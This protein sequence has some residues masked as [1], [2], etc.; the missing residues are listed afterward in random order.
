MHALPLTWIEISKS[1]LENNL[2]MFKSLAHN[3]LI[4]PVV[5][6]NAYGHGLLEIARLCQESSSADWLCTASLSDA[7]FLRT[8]GIIKPILVLSYLDE[9]PALAVHYGIDV[10]VYDE[11]TIKELSAIGKAI[12]KPV[13]IHIKVDTGMSRLGFF[14][15]EIPALIAKIQQL[16]GLVISGIATHFSEVAQENQQYT[17]QQAQAFNDLLLFLKKNDF[18]IPIRHAA[19]SAGAINITGPLWNFTRL[20]AGLYGLWPSAFTQQRAQHNH[21]GFTLQPIMTWKTRIITMRRLPAHSFVGYDRTYTTTRDTTMAILPMGYFD[22]YNRRLTNLGTVMV[23]NKAAKVMG[24]VCMNLLMIDV[25]DIPQARVGD[26]VILLGNHP[27]LTAHDMAQ[28]TEGRNPREVTTQ[29]N[30][31]IKRII[32]D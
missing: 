25:T 32:V 31:Q 20:G 21:T 12:G 14:P 17:Q 24:R 5:K 28:L 4:A 9:D 6:S 23:H 16:G 18:H 15:H 10:L 1:A 19:N 8:Q 30:A 13:A 2:R 22:G 11:A 29:L 3:T 27:G 7:V 26:E